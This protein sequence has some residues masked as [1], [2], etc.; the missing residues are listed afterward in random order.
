MNHILRAEVLKQHFTS[1]AFFCDYVT[2]VLISRTAAF[3]HDSVFMTW[4]IG[5]DWLFTIK[6]SQ[7]RPWC[8]LVCTEQFLR[9]N[10]WKWFKVLWQHGQLSLS[11]CFSPLATLCCFMWQ[12][13]PSN[14]YNQTLKLRIR[15]NQILKYVMQT[16][17]SLD[18]P[19]WVT[20]LDQKPFGNSS[21]HSPEDDSRCEHVSHL[22]YERWCSLFLFSCFLSNG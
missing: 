17:G 15:S 14:F 7:K 19:R 13:K 20:H 3:P 8:N 4:N 16:E 18:Q 5:R 1:L 21:S 22:E 6:V 2:V 11:V 9:S 10:K 12:F